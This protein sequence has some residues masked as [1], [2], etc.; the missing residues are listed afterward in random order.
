M[1]FHLSSFIL[2]SIVACAPAAEEAVEEAT[3]IEADLEAINRASEEFVAA[4]KANDTE[5]LVSLYTADVVLIPP[6][7]PAAK[8]SEAVR[9]WMRSFFDQFTMEDFT[10]STEEI[11]VADDWAFRSG[12]F[13]MTASPAAGGE[14]IEDAGIFIEIWQRQSDGSWKMVWDIWNSDNPPAGQ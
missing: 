5:G 9:V 10:I 12:T 3:T 6:N 2:L 7:E 14:Q 4:A 11:T 1:K 13:A 8:G